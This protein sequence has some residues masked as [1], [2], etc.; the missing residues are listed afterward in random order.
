MQ[1]SKVAL[2]LSA[3]HPNQE[4]FTAK[5]FLNQPILTFLIYKYPFPSFQHP[6]PD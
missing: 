1:I 6:I 3:V 2:S 4:A 5:A